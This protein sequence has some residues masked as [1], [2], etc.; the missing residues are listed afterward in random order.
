MYAKIYLSLS[1]YYSY[2]KVFKSQEKS[3]NF[4]FI[5]QRLDN[6]NF[7][8]KEFNSINK[9]ILCNYAS[10]FFAQFNFRTQKIF[11][12]LESIQIG[13]ELILKHTKLKDLE[14]RN[15]FDYIKYETI[16]PSEIIQKLVERSAD[17]GASMFLMPNKYVIKKYQELQNIDEMASVFKVSK[18]AMYWRIKECVQ[19]I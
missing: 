7:L 9:Q 16:L 13:K 5:Y 2:E 1:L 14:I 11:S 3:K 6:N 15:L 12:S 10:S 17:K 18:M 4:Y 19:T 8:E